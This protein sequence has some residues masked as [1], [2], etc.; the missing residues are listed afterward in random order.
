[1]NRFGVGLAMAFCRFG[2]VG[3]LVLGFNPWLPELP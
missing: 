3:F 1:M 2:S